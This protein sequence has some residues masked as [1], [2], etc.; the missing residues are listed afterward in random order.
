M[1]KEES[2]EFYAPPDRY[3]THML[4]VEM[5]SKHWWAHKRKRQTLAVNKYAIPEAVQISHAPR[6]RMAFI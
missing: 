2:A 6:I 1:H 5:H 4:R 3:D